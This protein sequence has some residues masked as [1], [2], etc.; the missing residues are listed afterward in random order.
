MSRV[1]WTRSLGLSAIKA[2]LL[3]IKGK[4]THLLLIV[5]RRALARIYASGGTIK[6]SGTRKELNSKDGDDESETP[7]WRGGPSG[8]GM[9]SF[10]FDRFRLEWD[11]ATARTTFSISVRIGWPARRGRFI[12]QRTPQK[13]ICSNLLRLHQ[14]I[15]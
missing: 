4:D 8:F 1:P 7:R 5:N 15:P 2:F 13:R 10:Y 11:M 12:Y 6:R 3:R 9:L 14:D